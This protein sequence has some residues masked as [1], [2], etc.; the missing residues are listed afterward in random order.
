MRRNPQ[1]VSI[2]RTSVSEKQAQR[3]EEKTEAAGNGVSQEPAPPGSK[4]VNWTRARDGASLRATSIHFP[5]A[6]A[7]RLRLYCAEHDRRLSE[8]ASEAVDKWLTTNSG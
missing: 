1:V 6:L 3:L 8:I 5:S 2:K 7:K 4:G